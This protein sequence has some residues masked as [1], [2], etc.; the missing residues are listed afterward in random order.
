MGGGNYEKN[1]LKRLLGGVIIKKRLT[2]TVIESK[3][4]VYNI[5]CSAP[6]FF[7]LQYFL[8]I[9]PNSYRFTLLFFKGS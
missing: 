3:K 9:F 4:V 1:V 6:S 5:H 2:N 7:P 8:E